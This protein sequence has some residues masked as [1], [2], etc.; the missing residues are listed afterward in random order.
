LR[1]YAALRRPILI[2]IHLIL[3]HRLRKTS[4]NSVSPGTPGCKKWSF[5]LLNP[6]FSFEIKLPQHC[7]GK[8][9][10]G[11]HFCY[12]FAAKMISVAEDSHGE[13]EAAAAAPGNAPGAQNGTTECTMVSCSVALERREVV[14]DRVVQVPFVY[15]ER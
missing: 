14:L 7:T 8:R 3:I 4:G 1:I 2:K 9:T 12:R 13:A 15:F 6:V 11:T 10:C 5:A